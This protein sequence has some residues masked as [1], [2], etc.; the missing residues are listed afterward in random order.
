MCNNARDELGRAQQESSTFDGDC[1]QRSKI[2]NVAA[3]RIQI[4]G[5]KFARLL[6]RATKVVIFFLWLR[7]LEIFTTAEKNLSQHFGVPVV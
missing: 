6:N 4:L 3:Q 2:V 1:H 7:L 5:W